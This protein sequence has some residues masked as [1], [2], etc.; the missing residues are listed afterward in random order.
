MKKQIFDVQPTRYWVFYCGSPSKRT[1]S[2]HC[3][4]LPSEILLFLLGF[5]CHE[6]LV[7]EFKL[8]NTCLLHLTRVSDLRL[9]AKQWYSSSPF[10]PYVCSTSNDW[11][12]PRS[13]LTWPVKSSGL[14]H[15]VCSN[16]R[17]TQTDEQTVSGVRVLAKLVCFPTEV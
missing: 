5:V 16:S 14:F 4:Q 13:T 7:P 2:L 9:T 1:H 15:I 17:Q 12:T 8:L 3:Y 11:A 6:K 10:H